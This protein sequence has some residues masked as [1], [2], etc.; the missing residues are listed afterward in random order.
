M[1]VRLDNATRQPLRVIVDS[2]LQTPVASKMLDSLTL[3]HSPVMIV[4]ADD[5]NRRADQLKAA[6]AELVLLPDSANKGDLKTLL[7]I[8][9]Q[10]GINEVLVE[11]GQG[12]N[13]ALL[14]A[15]LIDEF[16][17]YYAPKLMGDAA[18]AMF[19]MPELTE[20]QQVTEL[21]ILDVR[22]VGRDIRLQAKPVKTIT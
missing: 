10:R 8:L 18:K 5:Q 7:Q 6:G 21:Q 15:G 11:A 20:M 16:I 4:Y 1:T 22:Q 2:L 19:A 17:F 9:A 12:I 14:H 13:G 3:K